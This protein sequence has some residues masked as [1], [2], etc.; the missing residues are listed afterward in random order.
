MAEE[1]RGVTWG[2]DG[3]QFKDWQA[4]GRLYSAGF[5]DAQILGKMLAII[6]GESG[7]FLKAWHHN[8]AR[9][10]AGAILRD[11]EGKF[12]VLST[13]LGFIQKNIPHNPHV[14][15]AD[16]ESQGFVDNLFLH[17][18]EL[19]RGDSS[20]LIAWNMYQNR[21]FQPWYAYSNGGYLKHLDKACL[22]VGNYLGLMFLNKRTLLILNPKL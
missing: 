21:G 10:D 22:A 4:A 7:W 17:Y 18:P 14:K 5:K 13:D 12:T 11:S 8:V 20:S 3:D 15:L 1:I 6:A 2:L 19:A 16:S 9:D